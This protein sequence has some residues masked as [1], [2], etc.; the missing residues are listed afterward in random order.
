MIMGDEGC[1]NGCGIL[2][3]LN[4]CLYANCALLVI[5][6][7]LLKHKHCFKVL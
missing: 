7:N 6:T 5:E 3:K 1:G 2:L 4:G